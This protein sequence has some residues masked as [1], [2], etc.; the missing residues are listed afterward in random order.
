MISALL[1]TYSHVWNSS[2]KGTVKRQRKKGKDI[3]QGESSAISPK[4]ACTNFLVMRGLLQMYSSVRE[5]PYFL[6]QK[7]ASLR[8]LLE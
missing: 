4:D 5:V 6:A 2:Q 1:M 3:L 7:M 8:N